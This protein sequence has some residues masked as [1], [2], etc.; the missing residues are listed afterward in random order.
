MTSFRGPAVLLEQYWN[1]V[2]TG[3]RTDG[4]R[5]V[6]PEIPAD[7]ELPAEAAAASAN[8]ESAVGAVNLGLQLL[9]DGW[10][11]F[12]SACN[13]NTL[14]SSL[15]RGQSTVETINVTFEGASNLLDA[16]RSGG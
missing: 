13:N 14:T 4:C 8:L 5:Q 1:D 10:R 15:A 12:R 2:Q 6:D 9:R 11:E 7:Y 3:G 16:V